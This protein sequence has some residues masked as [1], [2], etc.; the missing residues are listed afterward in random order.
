MK[1]NRLVIRLSENAK[2]TL[3]AQAAIDGKTMSQIIR[4]LIEEYISNI[5]QKRDDV[6]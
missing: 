5:S 2:R 6:V 1:E 4:A 3:K